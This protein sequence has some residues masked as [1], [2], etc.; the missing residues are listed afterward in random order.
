M[1]T[2]CHHDIKYPN[3]YFLVSTSQGCQTLMLKMHFI[4]PFLLASLFCFSFHSS[5]R[6]FLVLWVL[7]ANLWNHLKMSMCL[8][9]MTFSKFKGEKINW[10]ILSLIYISVLKSLLLIL[11]NT[12]S[13]SFTHFQDVMSLVKCSLNSFL[14]SKCVSVSFKSVLPSSLGAYS[15]NSFT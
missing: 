12:S 3:I 13:T 14:N 1:S 6:S 10:N 4:E 11:P 2:L 15:K 7:G 9:S 8:F 5:D